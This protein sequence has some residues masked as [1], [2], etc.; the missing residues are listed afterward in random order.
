MLPTAAAASAP[1]PARSAIPSAGDD[2]D[3]DADRSGV[4]SAGCVR[5]RGCSG[6]WV[7]GGGP[8][9]RVGGAGVR[10]P[11]PGGKQTSV[12]S[13]VS[14]PRTSTRRVAVERP[15]ALAAISWR[16]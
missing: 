10:S 11:P 9:G 15:G 14:P 7:A 3:D 6:G 13:L 5:A 1:P 4:E 2:D 12:R 16:P 8:P